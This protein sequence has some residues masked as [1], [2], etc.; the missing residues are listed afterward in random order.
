MNP[1]CLIMLLFFL[2]LFFLAKGERQ[3]QV[4]SG[5]VMIFLILMISSTGFI[6]RFITQQ[7]EHYYP[8]VEQASPDIRW[9][10]VLGGGQSSGNQQPENDLL[11]G[12]SI[13]RLVEGVRLYRQ[14]PHAKLL[15]SG[16]GYGSDI[17]ESI[18]LAVLAKWFD[19]PDSDVVLETSSV[20]TFD[21]AVEIKKLL[22]TQPFYLVTSA[23]HMYRSMHLCQQQGLR[24]IATPADFTLYWQDERWEKR[25]LPH[26]QNLVYLNIALHELLGLAWAKIVRDL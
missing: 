8:I 25:Y 4:F 3:S 18:R 19:I 21:Q 1:L 15:L 6:P 7:L 26:P 13:K 12:T 24:P 10:V 5:F 9:V 14:L 20:N 2:L 11:Y 22:G 23:T 17:A 16:G